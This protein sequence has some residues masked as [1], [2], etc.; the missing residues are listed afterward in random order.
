V[1]TTIEWANRPGTKGEVWNP[2]TGC[3]KV[4]AG[5]KF[6][7]AETVA[8]RFWPT[9]YPPVPTPGCSDEPARPRLFTDL[10]CHEDRLALPFSWQRPRTV[11]VNS[12]SDLFHEAVPDEFIDKVFAVMALTPQCT[13]I[14]LTKRPERMRAYF[15]AGQFR[16]VK[17]ADAAKIASKSV[18]PFA[19][20][21]EV[22]F[23]AR[24]VALGHPWAIRAWP[25]PNVW[26]GVSVENQATADERIPLLLQT[27]AAV[28]VVSA[29]PL[30]GP[31]KC[32]RL[33][34][35]W[36]GPA[37][38]RAGMNDGVDWILVGGESG[39]QARPCAIEWIGALVEQTKAAGVPCFVKQLGAVWAYWN[40][41]TKRKAGAFP[42]YRP[43]PKGADPSEWPDALRV[44]EW[45]DVGGQ[46]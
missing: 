43:S 12:M 7:Y 28:R 9:Q 38:Q 42:K 32:E 44:R 29:E 14:V 39:P 34:Q 1:S 36:L 30:L 45:P 37:T 10:Q 25:L 40:G 33:G 3:T 41:A 8:N 27:S 21:S 24:S 35:H 17:V 46:P 11:F 6:C 31:I 4:S 16:D 5:C 15:A 23:D 20:P 13:F 2:V 22:V 18:V 26:L 19:L